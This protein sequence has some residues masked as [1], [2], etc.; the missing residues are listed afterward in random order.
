MSFARYSYHPQ[1]FLHKLSHVF[2]VFPQTNR[3]R[4]SGWKRRQ[5]RNRWHRRDDGNTCKIRSASVAINSVPAGA[6][7]NRRSG[8][9]R[10][11]FP[12]FDDSTPLISFNAGS[13]GVDLFFVISGF[14]MFSTTEIWQPVS[15]GSAGPFVSSAIFP[16]DDRRLCLREDLAIRNRRLLVGNLG[17]R[18]FNRFHSLRKCQTSHY[19]AI[20]AQGWTLNYEMFFYLCFG[21]TLLIAERWRLLACT[22]AFVCLI[23]IGQW[24]GRSGPLL[25]VYTDPLMFEFLFGMGLGNLYKKKPEWLVP[26]AF[27]I[28]VVWAVAALSSGPRFLSAGLLAAAFIGM[29]LCAE[30]A[31]A[32]PVSNALLL[33][34]DASY[35][36]YLAHGFVLGRICRVWK[37]A[38]DI[39]RVATNAGF[40]IVATAT[41]I[42]VAIMLYLFVERPI[43]QF[44]LRMTAG[45]KAG[46]RNDNV[47]AVP[48]SITPAG[49]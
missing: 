43:T 45:A 48:E 18:A 3:H 34:G 24:T 26:A 12:L 46:I 47:I 20:L 17:L 27:A 11:N 29:G 6:R 41:A 31:R 30:R 35:S 49:N 7:G 39:H 14:I 15:F 36:L 1:L 22:I 21:L 40:V 42:G 13:Y 28:I 32:V 16:A 33:L 19:T 4:E 2:G 37:H 8:A 38:F 5:A 25:Q 44:F 10:I 9:P 23:A